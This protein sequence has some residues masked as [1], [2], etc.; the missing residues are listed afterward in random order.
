MGRK[1]NYSTVKAS[2]DRLMSRIVRSRGRCQHCGNKDYEQ[3]QWCHIKSRRYMSIRYSKNNC[4]CLCARCHR[5]FT[6]NPDEHYQWI[7]ENYSNQYER[8]IA[9]FQPVAPKVRLWELLELEQ[10]LKEELELLSCSN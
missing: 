1:R 3:L 6:D 5:R 2:C 9:E 4:F 7:T 10:M 8:L